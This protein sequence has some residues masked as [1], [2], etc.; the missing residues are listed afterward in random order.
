MDAA[1]VCR[2]VRI[3]SGLSLRAL[4]Q[5]AGTSH[6]TLSAYEQGRVSPGADTLR[7]VCA[8]AGFDLVATLTPSTVDRVAAGRQLQDLLELTDAYPLGRTGALDAPV[9]PPRRSTA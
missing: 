4:A 7:R 3:R 6:A 2:R 1:A 8:A 9:F 5:R